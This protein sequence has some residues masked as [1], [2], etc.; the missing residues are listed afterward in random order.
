ME[1]VLKARKKKAD[2]KQGLFLISLLAYPILQF[3]IFYVIV[4][5]QSILL[6]F[7]TLN[8][9]FE[10]T[11]SGLSNFQAVWTDFCDS[12]ALLQ[13]SF[14]NAIRNYLISSVLSYPL[15]ILFA[16]VVYRGFRGVKAFRIIVM[17]PSIVSGMIMGLVFKRFVYAMPNMLEK[18][19]G[20]V[21]PDLMSD[22]DTVYG[23]SLF[24]SLWTGF[25]GAM[26]I[27]PNT[28]NGIDKEII[29]SARLDGCTS[30]QELWHI[31]LPMIFPTL[32]TYLVTGISGFLS[33]AGPVFLIWNYDAPT[34]VYN[35]GYFIFRRIMYDGAV[36]YG[37]VAALGLF[38]TF[39]S[40]P[41]TF[42]LKAFLE[43]VD[44][45]ND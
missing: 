3:I 27:Y 7:Q 13:T 37:Y 45:T 44:P 5:A 32:T 8:K 20:L 35:V 25:A 9:D 42:G 41:I 19:F 30:L 1:G 11:W 36:W 12:E 43:K 16:Y 10:W 22:P 23:V 21:I 24:Y 15:T 39:I 2:W 18:A 28:M 31:V 29:E 6:A 17:I 4:N 33:N 38:C 40:I 14:F 34:P 26:L